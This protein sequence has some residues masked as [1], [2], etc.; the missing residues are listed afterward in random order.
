[1]PGE[2]PTGVTGVSE[3]TRVSY[4]LQVSRSWKESEES[5]RR[6]TAD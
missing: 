5:V 4:V 3:E 1:M 6:E 2:E